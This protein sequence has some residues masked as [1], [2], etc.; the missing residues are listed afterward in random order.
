MKKLTRVFISMFLILALFLVVSYAQEKATTATLTILHTNDLHG[1]LDQL[2]KIGFLAKQVRQEVQRVVLLDAGDTFCPSEEA[3]VS[4]ER[5][6][7]I[8]VD[9]FNQV[10]YNAW[11]LGNHEF[12][13]RLG[14]L[15]NH[16]RSAS[17]PVLGANLLASET[18][19][20][21]LHVQPY[22]LIQVAG[23][24]IGILGLSTGS[25]R[26]TVADPVAAA[27]YY[28]PLLRGR[29]DVVVLLTHLGFRADSTLAASVEGIDV[30]V[31]GHTHTVL[32]SPRVVNGVIIGQAGGEGAFLG[33]IDLKV[34]DGQVTGWEGRLIPVDAAAGEDRAV[35]SAFDAWT[36]EVEGERMPLM[37]PLGTCGGGF[38]QISGTET[39]MGNL[40]ADLVRESVSAD[41]AFSTRVGMNPRLREGTITVLDFYSIYVWPRKV[42]VV[43]LDG[44]Q[45]R[46]VLERSLVEPYYRLDQSGMEVV[47]DLSRPEGKRV[48]SVTVGGRPL[49]P[50]AVYR[51][52]VDHWT[53]T[54]GGPARSQAD[55]FKPLQK[56]E[57][58]ILIRDL[59]ARHIRAAGV[60]RGSI[61]GRMREGRP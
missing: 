45:V 58:G 52:A 23:L 15:T 7:S 36:A 21:L 41:I 61:D 11:T 29:S 28:V 30:I 56:E 46:R 8:T 48:V 10:G 17:F 44:R 60:I 19:R 20:H 37:T 57:T 31:G 32:H 35:R 9:L 25:S 47:Y 43:S 51:V 27:R 16:L 22:A 55:T 39:A 4:K 59:L 53:A 49:D 14:Q 12:D 26:V 33:R 18:G 24:R 2:A 3:F 50:K 5:G 1:R 6:T 34:S 38:H 54:Y 40:I 42:M 13:R